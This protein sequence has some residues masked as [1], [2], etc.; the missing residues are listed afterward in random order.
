MSNV[1]QFVK[2]YQDLS[3]DRGYQFRFHCDQ[4]GNGYM[5]S[6]K[7]SKVAMA[8]GLLSAASSLF[9]GVF[10]RASHGSYE[11]QRAIGGKAHDD[12]L[13]EAV[14]EIKHKFKQ[15]SRCGKWVCPEICWNAPRG[16]CLSCAP[17]LA[18]ETAAAQ[19]QAAT[20]QI[21]EKVRK[22]DYVADI[23]VSVEATAACGSC[24][25]AVGASKFCPECGAPNAAK[26]AC[27]KCGTK[28]SAATR[29]CPECG[30]KQRP[31]L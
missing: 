28:M 6:Y 10:G 15:C 9:G 30:E 5:S 23:D 2:N 19:A 22:T 24:G 13:R 27:Q 16:L 8:S 29:F 3:T 7:T 17:D 18:R 14:E 11:L 12:A 20:E 25:A 21:K 31:A 26:V 4:C 1:I